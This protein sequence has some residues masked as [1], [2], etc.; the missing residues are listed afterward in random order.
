MGDMDSYQM[1]GTFETPKKKKKMIGT[2]KMP[3]KRHII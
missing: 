2:F 1:I 3:F